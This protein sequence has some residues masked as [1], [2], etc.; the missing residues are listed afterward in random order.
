MQVSSASHLL[1]TPRLLRVPPVRLLSCHA[2]H[3]RKHWLIHR[4]CYNSHGAVEAAPQCL[5]MQ[6]RRQA[7]QLGEKLDGLPGIRVLLLF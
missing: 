4:L 5:I 1:Q 7:R 2:V 6:S 3:P